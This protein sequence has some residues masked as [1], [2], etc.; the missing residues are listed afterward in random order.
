M[1][2]FK[3]I[4][5]FSITECCEYLRIDRGDLPEAVQNLKDLKGLDKLVVSR[6]KFLLDTDKATVESCGSIEQY[7]KY[8]ST[9]PDGLYHHF[10]R[11]KID[12]LRAESEELAFYNKYKGSSLGRK[13]YLRK[14][15]NGKH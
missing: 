14:Y 13:K 3:N 5:S 6:L 9:W 4:D 8:L 10:A 1:M 11:Q 7:E 12:Q 15:P 2:E